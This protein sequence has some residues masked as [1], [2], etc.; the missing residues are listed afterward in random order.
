MILDR[1]EMRTYVLDLCKAQ[2]NANVF[3]FNQTE[4]GPY[5]KHGTKHQGH[6]YYFIHSML[7]AEEPCQSPITI[8]DLV[9][10]KVITDSNKIF[11]KLT[12]G[13]LAKEELSVKY[14]TSKDF[15]KRFSSSFLSCCTSKYG[16]FKTHKNFMKFIAE[17][18]DLQ[19]NESVFAFGVDGDNPFLYHG[20]SDYSSGIVAYASLQGYKSPT[21][22]FDLLENT[23]ITQSPEVKAH[24]EKLKRRKFKVILDASDNMFQNYTS[25]FKALFD[26]NHD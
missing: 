21:T 13:P 22:L 2:K 9:G 4:K 20:V 10:E 18:G 16:C 3:V 8:I 23:I 14:D 12:I 25:R 7:K 26:I 1:N 5:Y 15:L 24:C 6:G 19:D 11:S 17:I